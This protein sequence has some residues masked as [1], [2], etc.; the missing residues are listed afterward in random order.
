MARTGSVDGKLTRNAEL[1]VRF[2]T[3]GGLASPRV[4]LSPADVDWSCECPSQEAACIHVAAAVIG[5]RKAQAEGNVLTA[6]T[7]PAI[8]LAHR[9][10]KSE[11]SLA[12]ERFILRNG[13]SL[14]LQTRLAAWK[15]RD[16]DDDVQADAAD[17]ALDVAL[18]PVV[19]GKIPRPLMKR[20]LAALAECK[21]V[22]FEGAPVRIG[23]PRP[24]IRARIDDHTE[25]FRVFAEQ[26]PD[27]Q[28]IFDNGA[29][30]HGGVLRAVGDLDL[31]GRDVDELRKGRTY[32][33]G[34]V[35][36][37]VGRVIP[38]LRERLPVEVASKLLPSAT[39]MQ[40]RLIAETEFVDG[41]LTVLPLLVYGDPP[42]ARVD[43]GK[44]HYLGGA[45]PLR[46]EDRER[47]LIDSLSGRT[48]LSVGTTARFMGRAALAAAERIRG[49]GALS[50]QGDGLSACFVSA[51]LSPQFELTDDRS[52]FTFVSE[53]EEGAQRHA[54]GAAVIEAWRRGEEFVPL[55]EGGFAPLP[56]AVL[57]RVGDL[58]ADLLA[59]KRD[60]DT[61]PACALPDL[62]RLCDA[63]Q[64]PAPPSFDRLRE[65]LGDHERIP[66][67]PLPSD[68]DAQ[69]RDYQRDGVNWLSFLSA[70]NLGAMLADDM[71][72]GKTLQALCVVKTP[73][74]VVAPA[75]VLHNWAAEIQRFRPALKV[76]VYHGPNRGIREDADITLTTYALLRLDE[77][78]LAARRWDT[79]ILDEA[80]NIKNADSQVARAAFRLDGRFRITLTGTP[81]ENR[82]DELWSQFHFANPGLLGGR[83]DFQERYARP[84]AEGDSRMG[85]RLRQRIRP[86][87]LRRLK[88][89]VA[90]ELPPRTDVVMRCTLSERERELYD[91]IMAA[92]RKEVIE[93]VAEGGNVLAALEALLRLRQAACHSGLIPGQTASTSA[94]LELLMDLLDKVL[95][96]D[97]KAL[98][99]SQWTSLLDRVEP[100][101]KAAGIGFARLD[102]STRDRAGVVAEF[103]SEQGPRIMLVSLKAGGTGLNLTAA[104][105][106]FLLDPWWNPAVE[107]QAADRAHRIGQERPVLVHRLV[108]ESTVEER[109]LVL[110]EKK[111]ALAQAA[112]HGTQAAFGLTREDLLAL[113]T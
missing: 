106:V 112:T 82:L 21:D 107:D 63:L 49:M 46:N 36:D 64:T 22:Q 52:S 50:V 8:K 48:G 78:V 25:G 11:G 9:L 97:H 91:A 104:D 34:Q 43:A 54:S 1:E 3:K 98:V 29:V 93:K 24:V 94:K 111:R 40:P 20:V 92:T 18:G 102:G 51:P 19:S 10:R 109:M 100:L 70:A 75:S 31:S 26:D 32:G 42:V 44:L 58:L 72:L 76:H 66:A 83:Q 108:A 13:S 47:K 39:P 65:L 55:I 88:R 53:S 60:D 7:A 86:F 89:E 41:A 110:Q 37:L 77:E 85:E 67:A 59:A 28:E 90:R 87:M 101:L 15:R 99:F 81:V 95:A 113:L 45:L 5:L 62:A 103:Q 4:V 14:P 96:E 57:T 16:G 105:H 80:Q 2:L 30:V 71:G 61:L 73:S 68:L 35:A 23:E 33:F 84:M 6:M 27:I 12:L 69:L 56:T 38:A 79:I 74:L 17:L